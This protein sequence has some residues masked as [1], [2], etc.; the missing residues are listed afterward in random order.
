MYTKN[1]RRR[2]KREN[3]REIMLISSRSSVRYLL[4]GEQVLGRGVVRLGVAGQTHP[5]SGNVLAEP[6]VDL[7]LSGQGHA[8][9]K[10]TASSRKPDKLLTQRHLLGCYCR[11]DY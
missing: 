6:L 4:L 7:A 5:R 1:H 11:P 9:V 3:E 10:V 8:K 2:S